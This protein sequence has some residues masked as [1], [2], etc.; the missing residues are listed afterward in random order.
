MPS[1]VPAH[2]KTA[3]SQTRT[4]ATSQQMRA[5]FPEDDFQNTAPLGAAGQA[6]AAPVPG[7]K[8]HIAKKTSASHIRA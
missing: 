3:A 5:A 1:T 8:Q 7:I 2:T 4:I 6:T